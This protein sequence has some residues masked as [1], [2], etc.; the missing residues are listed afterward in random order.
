MSAVVV[1][2]VRSIV[3]PVRELEKAV[4]S[5]DGRQWS[6]DVPGIARK[7]E[8]GSLARSFAGMADQLRGLVTA[9]EARVEE[10]TRDLTEAT[11]KAEAASRAKSEFLATMSHEI[12]TPMNGVLGMSEMLLETPLDERQRLFGETIRS[13]GLALLDVINDILDFSKVESGKLEVEAAPFDLQEAVED[14]ATLLSVPAREKGIDLLVRCAPDLP[15]R[16]VGDAGRVRQIVTNLLGNAIKFTESGHVLV[17][18]SSV[19]DEETANCVVEVV[20]TGI[21]IPEDQQRRIFEAFTQAEQSTTRKFGGTGLGLSITRK[22]VELMGGTVGVTS[23]LNVGSRFRV[24]LPLPVA[25]ADAHT[26]SN[27]AFLE[28]LDVALLTNSPERREILAERLS[29]WGARVEQYSEQPDGS[30]D[31]DL[32]VLWADGQE[33]GLRQLKAVRAAQGDRSTR[34]LILTTD[35]GAGSAPLREAGASSVLFRPVRTKTLRQELQRLLKSAPAGAPRPVS[36]DA[37]PDTVAVPCKHARVLVAEDNEVNRL[38]LASLIDRE[39]YDLVFA[40]NGQIAFETFKMDRF[41]AVLMDISMPIMDG[42]QATASIRRFERDNGL[43]R[44]P[45]ICLTAHAMADQKDACLRAEMDD[46]LSKPIRRQDLLA[47]LEMWTG[48]KDEERTALSA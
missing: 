3:G 25:P 2:A 14:V 45:V 39:R 16:V 20:D 26:T 48:E 23:N 6:I 46:Y 35:G 8:F 27:E 33:S 28:G 38:V 30:V 44:T 9:L 19:V 11:Q 17:E 41:D 5:H 36:A 1:W 32:L 10:R 24:V 47:L 18:V 4:R 21:G 40:E 37:A 13:S 12:R 31:A 34:V 43:S 7:D 29:S 15:Q 22:L 42:Y